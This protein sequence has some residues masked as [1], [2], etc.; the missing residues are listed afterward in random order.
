[1]DSG[2]LDPP[3]RRLWPEGA[4]I[5]RVG[6]GPASLPFRV[7]TLSPGALP[8][9][10]HAPEGP[11]D[12]ALAAFPTRQVPLA[13]LL[14]LLEEALPAGSRALVCDLVWQ[15]AP[16]PALLSSFHVSRRE[17]VR[18][19]EGYEMQMEHADFAIEARETLPATSAAE[20]PAQQQAL[21]ED[22]RGAARVVAW[23]LRRA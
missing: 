16:T 12:G 5:L 10:A 22:A 2:V 17:R 11:F 19:I 13:A 8:A 23:T 3:A 15:T 1:M 21:A 18:P 20:S 7:T 9:G 14:A 6:E 4:H